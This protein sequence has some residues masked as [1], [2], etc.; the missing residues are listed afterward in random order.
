MNAVAFYAFAGLILAAA[1]SVVRAH[2]PL[3]AM[4]GLAVCLVAAV[5]LYGIAGAEWL[6]LVVAVLAGL[7]TLAALLLA[8]L[9]LDIDFT[10][11]AR[12]SDRR[13][14]LTAAVS[15]L[16][17]AQLYWAIGVN[18][19]SAQPVAAPVQ[20]GS[21]L[22]AMFDGSG[23]LFWLSGLSLMAGFLAV[24]LLLRRKPIAARPGAQGPRRGQGRARS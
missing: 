24:S 10:G 2:N 20:E 13:M 16:I 17:L 12:V 18:P 3:R 21:R 4:V 6:T 19:Q 5:G 1:L 14:I 11:F 22:T 7:I 23:V 15:L 8:L 9:M